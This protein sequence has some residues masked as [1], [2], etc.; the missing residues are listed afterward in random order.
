[1]LGTFVREVLNFY[2]KTLQSIYFASYLPFEGKPNLT[3][4]IQCCINNASEIV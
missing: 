4:A 2:D 3:Y 1:M